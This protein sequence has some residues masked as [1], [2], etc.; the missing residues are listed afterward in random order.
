MSI[1]APTK[2]GKYDIIEVLGRGGMGVVYKAKDPHL[3]RLVAIKMTGGVGENPELVSRFFREAQS[4][5][6]LQHPNI[7]TVYELGDWS[8][9][10]YLVMEYLEGHSLDAMIGSKR[11]LNII[12]QLDIMLAVCRGLDYAHQRKIIHRDIKPANIVVLRDGSVKLVD[13]GIAHIVGRKL[14]LPGQVI[15]SFNYM[16]PEQINSKPIDTRTDIFS[17]GI[18]LYQLLTKALPFQAENTAATLMKIVH[19]APPPLAQFLNVYPPELETIIQRALAKDRE[20]RYQ[21]IEEFAAD[22]RGVRE[23]VRQEIINRH[24]EDASAL[25]EA[26]ALSKAKEEVFQALKWDPHHSRAGQ[27]MREILLRIEGRPVAR[28]GTAG[29]GESSSKESA[30]SIKGSNATRPSRLQECLQEARQEIDSRR[31][32]SA[33]EIL[34][35]AQSLDPNAQQVQELV[36]SATA[37]RETEKKSQELTALRAE[38]R[39]AIQWKDYAGA[40]EKASAGLAKFPGDPGLLE[41]QQILEKER[42]FA[43]R[44]SNINQELTSAQK[45]LEQGR[46]DEVITLLSRALEKF[47]QDTRLDSL[48]RF[49]RE[50]AERKRLEKRK[51]DA[52]QAAREQIARKDYSSAIRILE[53]AGADLEEKAE[54]EDLLQNIKDLAGAEDRKTKIASAADRARSLI[55]AKAYADAIKLLE[56]TLAEIRDEEMEILL[57]QARKEAAMYRRKLQELLESAEDLLRE[58]KPEEAL[59]II[60]AESSYFYS[61]PGWQSLRER[62]GREAEAK[63]QTQQAISEARTLAEAGQYDAARNRLAECKSRV[64]GSTKID[65]ELARIQQLRVAESNKVLARA[66]EE[67]IQMNGAREY[68]SAIDKLASAA[69]LLPDA[70]ATLRLKYEDAQKIA[71]D[72]IIRRA[73]AEIEGHIAAGQLTKA[74][75]S[76]SRT[77]TNL[78]VFKALGDLQST[79]SDELKRRAGVQRSLEDA[80][81]LVQNNEWQQAAEL[82]RR[83]LAQ[84]IRVVRLKED[85]IAEFFRAAELSLK[86]GWRPCEQLLK[87]FRELEP[88]GKIPPSLLTKMAE[89]RRE[90]AVSACLDQAR[91]LQTKGDVQRARREVAQLAA[92]YP[93]DGRLTEFCQKLDLQIAQEEEKERQ[94]RVRK[95]Q[96]MAVGN[97]IRRADAETSLDIRASIL[98]EALQKYPKDARLQPQIN[99]L[100]ELSHRISEMAQAAKAREQA[101]EYEQALAKWETLRLTY[102]HYPELE[103]HIERVKKLRDEARGLARRKW[104]TKIKDKIGASNYEEASSLLSQATTEFPWDDELMSLQRN[105]EE[106]I[107][108]R[109]KAEKHLAAAQEA[110][111][112]RK[113]EAG[114]KAAVKACQTAKEDRL[115][116]HQAMRELMDACSVSREQEPG[117]AASTVRLLS[118]LGSPFAIPNGLL[119]LGR[120]PKEKSSLHHREVEGPSEADLKPSGPGWMGKVRDAFSSLGGSEQKAARSLE[121]QPETASTPLPEVARSTMPP[122]GSPPQMPAAESKRLW[123]SAG[124]HKGDPESPKVLEFPIASDGLPRE[125]RLS[126]TEAFMSGA[127]APSLPERVPSAPESKRDPVDT[128]ISSPSIIR[129]SPEMLSSAAGSI[130]SRLDLRP[131]TNWPEE[132]LRRIEKRLATIVGPLARVLVNR[133]SAQTNNLEELLSLLAAKLLSDS[134]R[135]A[136]LAAKSELLA[137]AAAQAGPERSDLGSNRTTLGA[138]NPDIDPQ[139]LERTVHILARYV[140]PIASV[141]VKRAATRA[142]GVEELYVALAER[143]DE[144]KR[145]Q[146]LKECGLVG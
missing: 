139:S 36:R 62:A 105:V 25:I 43:E 110:F 6:S 131:G 109:N 97:A 146:F 112:R 127:V 15:G 2:I 113:W 117:F 116:W 104:V 111:A 4:T 91:L 121:T 130:P 69:K 66:I 64:T 103:Q 145:A 7:V 133:A 125:A 89:M 26:N 88:Q 54:I 70:P 98:G 136:F 42:S 81:R 100:K 9:N 41:L 48:L 23:Q 115:V 99:H 16:S 75:E 28:D 13:F 114:R 5:A 39:A 134:D 101:G 49:V 92:I 137:T 79:L 24:L 141:L 93:T 96:E 138:V 18:V 14:T 56:S 90:E 19:E 85:L 143:V 57:A 107:K 63:Q 50:N 52:L 108:A 142:H 10:P 77:S 37:A 132:T 58:E 32:A 83:Q 118:E 135:K 144:N 27:L 1:S 61:E 84:P 71:S 86:T 3:G 47:G 73:R 126:A 55:G 8:G 87:Q 128:P 72:A 17:A 53:A 22:L 51:H 11:P 129:S 20:E 38:I 123:P 34:K 82:L 30:Q 29:S 80:R 44:R 94:E 67:A 76:L 45:L 40:I 102:R 21:T 12:E 59:K 122:I 120:E 95:E 31:F 78:T 33:L 74:Q 68:D 35:E 106:A 140:G 119:E 65:E 124:Q 46:E 60:E